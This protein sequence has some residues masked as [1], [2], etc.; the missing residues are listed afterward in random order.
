MSRS[1]SHFNIWWDQKL[2][3]TNHLLMAHALCLGIC[4][5]TFLRDQHFDFLMKYLGRWGKSVDSEL[6]GCHVS[7]GYEKVGNWIFVCISACLCVTL[8]FPHHWVTSH[9]RRIKHTDA[10]SLAA[11]LPAGG[12]KCNTEKNKLSGG[13]H[14]KMCQWSAHV[15]VKLGRK[16]QKLS[17]LFSGSKT[18]TTWSQKKICSQELSLGFPGFY[19]ASHPLHYISPRGRNRRAYY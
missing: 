2:L 5:Y 8:N 17:P 6:I 9:T 14:F 11:S 12:V 3:I 18:T 16:P 1:K 13:K 7:L 4:G 19:A 10:Q 15:Y